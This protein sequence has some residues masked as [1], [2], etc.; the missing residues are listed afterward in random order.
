MTVKA[1]EDKTFRGAFIASLTLP[2]GFAVNA[3]EGGGGYH[4]VWAR[5]LYHQVT[6][7]LAAGD[8]A[9]ANRAV[10]WLFERQQQADGTFPQNSRVD[11]EPDQRNIQLDETAFPLVLAYQ[12]RRTD[13][14]DGVRRAAEALVRMGPSTPQERWEETGGYSPST[15]AAEIAVSS[16]PPGSRH[17]AATA[18]GS[19]CGSAS[20]TSG[21]ATPRS[22]CS[23]PPA[24][25]ATGATTCASTPTPTRT[26]TTRGIGERGRGAPGEGGR[27]R[28]VPG[29]GPARRQGA[30]R[31]VRAARSPRRTRRW[32]PTRRAAGCG[33][34]TP[35]TATARRTPASR[36]RSTPRAPRA[37]PGRCS[38]ASAASTRSPAAAAACRTCA[39]WPTPP[40]TA[41]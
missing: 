16:L 20:P 15:T 22:G 25:T 17:G 23:P 41:T 19:G 8:R 7:L 21:S 18:C 28:R 13:L 33:T 11:G 40:T 24:R 39:R 4:F 37:A 29:A 35:S 27:R 36:G 30:R 9:A 31:P 6:G 14:W 34:A 32:R 2:W 5:D 10:T 26:T 3:D 1:H 38:A 12:L